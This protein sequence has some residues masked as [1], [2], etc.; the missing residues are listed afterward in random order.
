MDPTRVSFRRF[1]PLSYEDCCLMAKWEN[2]PTIKALFQVYQDQVAFDWVSTP[3]EI[4]EAHAASVEN[5]TDRNFMI[6]LDGESV[7]EMNFFMDRRPIITPKLNTA[8]A[9]IVIGEAHARAKGVG[10]L[11][12][13]ELERVA[14][15]AGAERLELGVFE[16]NENAIKFYKSLGYQ[17]IARLPD[18]TWFNGRKWTD[19]RMLKDPL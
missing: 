13:R 4:S 7:G 2:D 11:A 19:I 14:K 17:E 9:G 5:P 18:Y 6:L 8:W 1:D 16:Y 15:E 10:K 3:E 12:F